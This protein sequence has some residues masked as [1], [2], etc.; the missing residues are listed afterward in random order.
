MLTLLLLLLLLVLTLLLLLLL[1][2]L[3]TGNAA[4]SAVIAVC[5]TRYNPDV[6]GAKLQCSTLGLFAGSDKVRNSSINLLILL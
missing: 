2:Q 4:V 5:P 6:V 1:L 3:T